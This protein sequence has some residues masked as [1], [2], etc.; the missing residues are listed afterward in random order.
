MLETYWNLSVIGSYWE[1]HNIE[2]QCQT[3]RS[4]ERCL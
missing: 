4:H 3:S 1:E 2:E